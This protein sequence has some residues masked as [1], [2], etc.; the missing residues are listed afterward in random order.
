MTSQANRFI[1]VGMN[2]VVDV[3]VDVTKTRL[4]L[5]VAGFPTIH[6]RLS[7]HPCSPVC[8]SFLPG[9]LWTALEDLQMIWNCGV[10]QLLE[11]LWKVDGPLLCK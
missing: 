2:V 8:R 1:G 3:L 7:R 5:D 4:Q 6:T 10:V 11:S 9:G